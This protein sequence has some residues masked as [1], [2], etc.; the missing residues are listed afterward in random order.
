MPS[1]TIKNIPEP[2]LDRVRQR[3]AAEHRSVNKEFLQLVE[4]ALSGE[5]ARAAVRE[6]VAQQTAAWSGLA[7][8]WVSDVDAV[9][10]VKAIYEART[11][12]RAV[13]L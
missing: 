4:M 7:G 12:G 11:A 2:L 13:D 9:D 10:E 6:Q 3:A 1:I 5:Q 8:S